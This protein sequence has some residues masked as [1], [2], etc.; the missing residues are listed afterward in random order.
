MRSSEAGVQAIFSLL[1]LLSLLSLV[2]SRGEWWK[3]FFG[4]QPQRRRPPVAT[5]TRSMPTTL[6]LKS[7]HSVAA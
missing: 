5:L 7:N 3:E 4:R 1:S 6:K 2:L